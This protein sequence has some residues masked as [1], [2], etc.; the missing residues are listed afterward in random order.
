[1]TAVMDVHNGQCISCWFA[2]LSDEELADVEADVASTDGWP[3]LNPNRFRP[4]L[5]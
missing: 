2:S 3:W 1:M 4:R 5:T